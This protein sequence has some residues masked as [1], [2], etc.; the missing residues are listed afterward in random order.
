MDALFS[1][2]NVKIYEFAVFGKIEQK[3]RTETQIRYNAQKQKSSVGTTPF[4]CASITNKARER[5][6]K[7][8]KKPISIEMRGDRAQLEERKN[9]FLVG[10][11]VTI[12]LRTTSYASFCSRIGGRFSEDLLKA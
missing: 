8:N 6:G 1:I 4:T 7:E 3:F 2:V 11:Y 10:F 12:T 9:E 5:R